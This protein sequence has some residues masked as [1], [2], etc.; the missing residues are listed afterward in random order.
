MQK[1]NLKVDKSVK[2]INFLKKFSG[3]DNSLLIEIDKDV[4]KAKSYTPEK[5]V[6]KYSSIPLDEVFSEYSDINE[7]IK[8]GI[9]NIDKLS[10]SFKFFGESE[11]NFEITY[12]AVNGENAGTGIVLKNSSLEIEFQCASLKLFTYITDDILVKITNTAQSKVD[13]I[14]PKET[15]AKLSSLFGIDSDHPK[16]T[17]KKRGNYINAEGKNFKLQVLDTG[18]S[19]KDDVTI[20]VFKH[21]YAFLDREDALAYIIEDKLIFVSNESDTKMIIGEAE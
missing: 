16:I 12:A 4:V 17:F 6:V 19:T 7:P 10:S 5:S 2:F 21:H 3:I 1:L 20:S 14:L 8:L 9:M 11:F 15:Q 13:F 18:V